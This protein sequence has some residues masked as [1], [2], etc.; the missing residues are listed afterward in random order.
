[1]TA[2]ELSPSFRYDQAA[3]LTDIIAGCAR[4]RGAR[5][6]LDIGAG[7]GTVA[8]PV[9]RCVRRY[10]AVEQCQASAALLR[11][12]RLDVVTASFPVA[13]DERFDLVVSSHSIPEGGASLYPPFLAAAWDR[14]MPGGL[15]L[16]VTFKGP[17]DPAIPRLS[18]EILGRAR[19]TDPRY[20]LMLKILE[21][22]GTMTVARRNSHVETTEF[23]DVASFFGGWFWPTSAPEHRIAAKLRAAVDERFLACGTYRVPTQHFV[24]ATERAR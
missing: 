7:N 6:L 4:A 21:T 12:A 19:G 2:R 11:A 8:I 16:I 3:V 24:I 14:V 15:L 22:F 5:S 10:L 23:A 13:I 18:Q 20:A 9:S 17:D 1:M